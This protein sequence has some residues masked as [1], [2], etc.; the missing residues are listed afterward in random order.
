M[1]YAQNEA[2]LLIERAVL[3]AFKAVFHEPPPVVA[4]ANLS[5]RLVALRVDDDEGF[6]AISLE[7]QK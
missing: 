1:A 5:E 7:D 6:F 3:G 2:E 4:I